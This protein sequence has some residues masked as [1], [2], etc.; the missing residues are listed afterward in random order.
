M[1]T[2]SSPHHQSRFVVTSTVTSTTDVPQLSQNSVIVNVGEPSIAAINDIENMN[3]ID[4]S[5]YH[6]HHHHN[7]DQEVIDTD[8]DSSI[9]SNHGEDP[10]KQVIFLLFL[11]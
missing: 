3:D 11:K 8:T 2:P 10:N 4:I 6:H 7:H 1:S 5:D 9:D